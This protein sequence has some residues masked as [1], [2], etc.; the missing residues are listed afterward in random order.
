MPFINIPYVAENNRIDRLTTEKELQVLSIGDE[1]KAEAFAAIY[2]LQ[3]RGVDLPDPL[4]AAAL[5]TLLM[6]LGIPFRRTD[7][8][9]YK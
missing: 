8:S 6:R 3:P 2:N 9:E 7:E 4:E 5:E 1:A